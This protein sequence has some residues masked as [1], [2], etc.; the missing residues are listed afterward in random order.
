MLKLQNYH[1]KKCTIHIPLVKRTGPG[2]ILPH[3]HCTDGAPEETILSGLR[4][5]GSKGLPA[6]ENSS[7]EEQEA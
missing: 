2:L 5:V 1:G 3:M 7:L 4:L 6:L